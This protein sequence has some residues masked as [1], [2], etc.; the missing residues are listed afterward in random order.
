MILSPYLA[1][2]VLNS[3][4]IQDNFKLFFLLLPA[5]SSLV[6]RIFSHLKN[7]YLFIFNSV[8]IRMINLLY[9]NIY[10]A[11]LPSSTLSQISSLDLSSCMYMYVSLYTWVFMRDWACTC[12]H[13]FVNVR[14]QLQVLF[15]L[16]CSFYVLR[17]SVSVIWELPF[18]WPVNMMDLSV[19][20]FITRII[21]TFIQVFVTYYFSSSF[22]SFY[23]ICRLIFNTFT[24]YIDSYK[25]LF[26]LIFIFTKKH[27]HSMSLSICAGKQV[28]CAH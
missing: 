8:S 15:F 13:M 10:Y 17:Q 27:N 24:Q 18:N 20:L 12:V 9:F 21:S 5:K 23:L 2:N 25:R 4:C 11:T 1:Q 26:L 19:Y 14:T 3:L 22:A 7:S 6:H 16:C 28:C